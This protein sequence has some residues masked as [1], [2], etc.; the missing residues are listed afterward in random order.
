MKT[1]VLGLTGGIGSGKTTIAHVFEELGV[2]VYYADD[3]AKKI[4]YLPEVLPELKE[5]FG[6]AVFVDGRPDRAKIAAVVFADKEKLQALN[7]IIHPRVAQHFN[8]W[9]QAHNNYKF[10]IKEAA[11]LFESG[12]YK[13]C[14]D[15]I[16][17][18]APTEDRVQRVMQ[19]DGTTREQV[20]QRIA[21]QWTEEQKTRLSKY[22]ITNINIDTAR[23]E[24]VKLFKFLNNM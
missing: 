23:S 5:N 20:L 11:I 13:Q 6:D 2:P 15:I 14:D 22:I 1:K 9:L 24:A 4:L 16:L 21:N 7:N 8:N 17:V 10:V 12:S 3:E 19:R 18:T